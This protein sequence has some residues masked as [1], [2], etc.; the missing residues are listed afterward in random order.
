MM[1]CLMLAVLGLLV[2]VPDAPLVRDLHRL[3]VK[4][5]VRW[6]SR[7]TPGRIAFWLGL[8]LVGLILFGLF[9]ADGVRLFSFLAPDVVLWFGM[10]DVALFLDVFL[11][12]AAMIATTR[13]R[14]VRDRLVLATQKAWRTVLLH[15]GRGRSRRV[16]PARPSK[17]GRDDADPWAGLAYAG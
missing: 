11:I 13:V 3:L 12:A 4:A 16:R 7:V 5:P 8:S 15:I 9:E 1:L 17:P 10:F 6:L 2:L 14:V